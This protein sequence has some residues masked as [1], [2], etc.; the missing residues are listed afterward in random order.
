MYYVFIYPEFKKVN[1]LNKFVADNEEWGR[2]MQ[3][4]ERTTLFRL[5]VWIYNDAV[6]IR[7]RLE[8]GNAPRKVINELIYFRVNASIF[9]FAQQIVKNLL[10]LR[11]IFQA[12]ISKFFPDYTLMVNCWM[13][14]I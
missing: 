5:L 13:I 2:H 6:S 12:E 10:K 7:E 1:Q 11:S 14:K 8:N 9:V 3:A 4:L